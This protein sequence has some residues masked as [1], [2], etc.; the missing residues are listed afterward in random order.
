MTDQTRTFHS[1]D[2][3]ID[4]SQTELHALRDALA[5]A[6]D[7]V[8]QQGTPG[9]SQR[10]IRLRHALAVHLENDPTSAV[11]VAA[12]VWLDRYGSSGAPERMN[13]FRE[14]VRRLETS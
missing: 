10:T 14:A 4:I 13:K 3:H 8:A 9:A 12:A 1:G 7:L 11:L 5:A 6:V 2:L